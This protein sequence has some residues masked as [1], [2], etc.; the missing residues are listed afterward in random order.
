MTGFPAPLSHVSIRVPWHDSAWNGTVCSAPADNAACLVLKRIHEQKDDAAEVRVAGR[1][2]SDLA[3]AQ[4]PP[5]LA[6]RVD[7][8]SPHEF[9]RV[10]E[11]PYSKTS[12]SH[13]HFL[14]TRLRKPPFSALA[15]PYRWMLKEY[16]REIVEEF[17][18]D[19]DPTLEDRAENLMGFKAIWVQDKR[20]QLAM[21]DR[22]F[23]GVKPEAS[24]CFLYAKET[25]LTDD[26]RRAIVGV[27]RVMSVG[28][29]TEYAYSGPGDLYS[30]LWE[31]AVQHSIRPGFEDGFL[32]PY[33]RLHDLAQQ[34]ESHN[35]AEFVALAPEEHHYEFS[36]GSEYVSHDGAI[37]A[38]VACAAVVER[39]KH[40]VGGQ[41]DHVLSW[42]DGRLNEA[43]RLRGPCPGIG[44]V[45][46]AFG[47]ENGTL[48]AYELSSLL[49]ENE[50]PWP[51]IDTLFTD[52]ASV[53]SSLAKQ[54]G[55]T[56]SQKW[57]NLPDERR[58]LLKLISRFDVRAE[59]ATRYY[60][61]TEREKAG[62]RVTDGELLGNAYL[63]YELDR[64]S[65]EPVTV[66][67]VDRGLFPDPVVREAHP[68][69]EP[70]R[71]H[72]ATDP[73]RVRALTVSV[74]E[75]ASSLGDTLRP[76]NGVIQ[77][78][79]EL[80]VSP[81]CPVDEDLM[82]IVEPEFDPVVSLAEMADGTR[83][84]QIARLRDTGILIKDSVER[85]LKGKRHAIEAGW[86]ALL[87]TKLG[88]PAE[89]DD[90]PELRAR[91]EK[92]RAL[93]ELAASRFS[94]LIG[95]A[96]T[97]KTTLLSV[98]C[99]QP[100]IRGGGVLLLAPTGKAR[101]QLEKST[102]I[103]AQTIAQFL[104]PLDRY[105]A[106]TGLY[107]LSDREP[108][109][110]AKTVVIDEASMLTE[111]QLAAVI[112]SR[113]GVERMILSGDPRQLPPIGSGRPFVDIVSRLSPE[114]VESRF[115]RIGV[116]GYCELTIRR[117][118]IG[119]DRDD[120][121]LAEWFSGQSPGAGSDEIWS[122][123]EAGRDSETIRFLKWTTAQELHE[124]LTAV[125]VEE[126]SLKGIDDQQGF[127]KSLGGSDYQGRVFFWAARN[128]Q[129][130][131]ASVVES[132]QV[133]SPL[134]GNPHGILDLNRL[135]QR[136]F[137]SSRLEETRPEIYYHRKIPEPIGPQQILYGDKVINTVNQRR[138]KVYPRD[139]SLTYVANGEIGVVVGQYKTRQMN[140]L[141]RDLEVEFSSQPS[142]K[143]TFFKGEFGE[144]G[145]PPLELGYALTV[146]KAQGSEFGLTFLI[147]P[148]PCRLLSRELLYTAF[149]RQRRRVVIL[150]QGDLSELKRY[151]SPGFS[152]T[153]RRLTN[154]FGSPEP[155]P[156]EDRFLED[157]L[158]HRTRR[159]ELVRSKSEVIIADL[160]YSK[161]LDYEYDQKLVAQD[162][163][164][165]YPDF[166]IEDSETGMMIFWEHLGMLFDPVYRSRWEIKL[167]WY[168]R[169]GIL[170]LEEGSSEQQLLVTRD[171]D[172][173]GIDSSAIESLI[174]THFGR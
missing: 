89:P 70:T 84:Y 5:C 9:V 61:P 46:T 91:E 106:R 74:L 38:L 160:L 87:D 137:R 98:L 17:G 26:P 12:K 99:E 22:F 155:V 153:A 86:E 11:H 140:W 13:T 32:L 104:L 122:A 128:G 21:L 54:I 85:R 119:E 18:I 62:I 27:G 67:A 42:I 124:K 76:K 71:L 120:L 149:T 130:G 102:G 75:E 166:T 19:F 95:P 69:R 50:D 90:G 92:V 6:E 7:F 82:A 101:V 15:I 44:A 24:L 164:S 116:P 20:N 172:R 47:V 133:F 126:L 97:G 147:L 28:A 80:A 169:Q 79:R 143:Y 159:G 14:A 170:P 58:E 161:G 146:H 117:R 81:L 138:D 123:V 83:A 173:G 110:G 60:Q 36:Y 43:W 25:P 66:M 107:H 158:I 139:D 3:P 142:Y 72:D 136:T 16:A 121:M 8:M 112:Q 171:D 49:K 145:N 94:V 108:Q 93:E 167:D 40:L 132:W 168:R 134:R 63:L 55:P 35:P 34:D 163:T 129:P 10:V 151:T 23:A 39:A 100:Q 165:R 111:E 53:A 68:L 150:H 144:E 37:A 113:K 118:Q 77:A 174:K 41:W 156:F 96:G 45:L 73:R 157:R 152:E 103:R 57:V 59:Q 162:G 105:D 125:L 30:V 4:L 115:P 127:E 148:N 56:L 141:P 114:D 65:H 29:H 154:L 135:I 109:N 78:I 88:G 33:H 51:L 1:A 48:L 31:R 131:A 2:F 52:P 64:H